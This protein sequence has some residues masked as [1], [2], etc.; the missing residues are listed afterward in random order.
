MNFKNDTL[1]IYKQTSLN[2]LLEIYN[3]Y[4]VVKMTVLYRYLFLKLDFIGIFCK[5][6]F[7][8]LQKKSTLNLSINP[9]W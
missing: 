3:F 9:I 1:L 5:S 8:K 7:K 2:H 6:P 4:L